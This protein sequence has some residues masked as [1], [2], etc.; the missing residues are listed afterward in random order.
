MQ[1]PLSGVN[2]GTGIAWQ[3]YLWPEEPTEQKSLVSALLS[4]LSEIRCHL[5]PSGAYCG[6]AEWL[7]LRWSSTVPWLAWVLEGSTIR[8]EP[9]RTA[10]V[11]ARGWAC[12]VLPSRIHRITRHLASRG[13]QTIWKPDGEAKLLKGAFAAGSTMSAVHYKTFSIGIHWWLSVDLLR[14]LSIWKPF[15]LDFAYDHGQRFKKLTQ[16][17]FFFN[18]PFFLQTHGHT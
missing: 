8:L 3:C 9:F 14:S 2:Q 1:G 4:G 16:D 5:G 13:A 12:L 6:A 11:D 10:L 18:S 7:G 17:T 15:A